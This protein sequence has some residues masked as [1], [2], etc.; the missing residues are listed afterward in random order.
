MI[1]VN[2]LYGAMVEAAKETAPSSESAAGKPV[3]FFTDYELRIID[4][5]VRCVSRLVL[6]AAIYRLR[7]TDYASRFTVNTSKSRA[8]LASGNTDWA[9]AST[10]LSR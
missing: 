10:S 2:S 1:M 6:T 3:L 9:S 5:S 4:Y 8:T 7:I